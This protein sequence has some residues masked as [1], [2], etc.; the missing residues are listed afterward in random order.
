MTGRAPRRGHAIEIRLNAE[1]PE[2]DFRPSPGRI[3]RFQA[4]QGPGVR[5]DTF[6]EGGSVIPPYYDSLVAKLIVWD[7]DRPRRDRARRARACARP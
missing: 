4:P 5:V 2:L 6:L 1:D 3:A 7:D